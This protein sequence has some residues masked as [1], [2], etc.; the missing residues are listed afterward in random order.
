MTEVSTLAP[1]LI[2]QLL[3]WPSAMTDE[4]IAAFLCAGNIDRRTRQRCVV[5]YR[6]AQAAAPREPGLGKQGAAG[7]RFVAKV[8]ADHWRWKDVDARRSASC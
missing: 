6:R 4:A 3:T 1:L 7:P 8:L 5:F 2:T